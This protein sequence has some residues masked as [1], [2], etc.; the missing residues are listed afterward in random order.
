MKKIFK[1]TSF[2]ICIVL[3]LSLCACQKVIETD[4]GYPV[5][6]GKITL[7]KKP[8][9]VVCLTAGTVETVKFLSGEVVLAGVCDDATTS[10]QVAKV[11][12]ALNPD[13]DKIISLSPDIVFTNENL[14]EAANQKLTLAGVKV[15]VVPAPVYFNEVKPYY[16][17]FAN[18]LFGT[19]DAP[20]KM[21]AAMQVFDAPQIEQAQ[22][23]LLIPYANTVATPDTVMGKLLE[24]AGFKNAAEGLNNFAMV[25]W[26]TVAVKPEY[27]FCGKGMR[28]SLM[29]DP[30][31]ATIP[32]VVND[33]V[34]EIDTDSLRLPGNRFV[35]VVEEM[36]SAQIAKSFSEAQTSSIGE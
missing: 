34:F 9:K 10:T 30:L 23:A 26:A 22:T 21:E 32:A 3:A 24:S 11:G 18:L 27:I 20:E 17:A 16:E 14:S 19:V 7:E 2:L 15:A 5:T 28:E 13:L 6:Q 25:D 29:A 31:L 4:Q 33:K 35:Q 12:T 8:E 36:K 1:I